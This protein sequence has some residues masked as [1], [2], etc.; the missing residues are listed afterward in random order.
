M[1]SYVVE[2]KLHNTPVVSKQKKAMEQKN[3]MAFIYT[4]NFNYPGDP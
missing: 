1:D 4:I 2:Y 3:P